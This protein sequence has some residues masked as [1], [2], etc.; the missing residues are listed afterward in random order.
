MGTG[1]GSEVV[2]VAREGENAYRVTTRDGCQ[3]VLDEAALN[4]LPQGTAKLATLKIRELMAAKKKDTYQSGHERSDIDGSSTGLNTDGTAETQE[5][6]VFVSEFS[7]LAQCLNVV[8][9]R[10][11]VM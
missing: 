3:Q 7:T 5:C 6:F 4:Q 10:W 11:N 1:T 2:G 8:I 9:E